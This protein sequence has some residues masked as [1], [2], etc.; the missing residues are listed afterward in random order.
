QHRETALA[1]SNREDHGRETLRVAVNDRHG[2]E[3]AMISEPLLKL[4]VCPLGKSELRLEG[5]SLVCIRCAPRFKISHEGYP[6]MLIEEAEL[7]PGCD[8][9][10]QLQCVVENQPKTS[11]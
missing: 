10:D 7:P 8:H 1:A 11:S 3:D 4:L 5:D 9:S 2:R 6:N